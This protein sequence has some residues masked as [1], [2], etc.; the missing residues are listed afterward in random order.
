MPC[1]D[2][3]AERAVLATVL[4]VPAKWDEASA[5]LDESKFYGESSRLV[6]RSLHELRALG[7]PFDSVTVAKWLRKHEFWGRQV[8]PT[9]FAS[10]LADTPSVANVGA[11]A[12]I[13]HE[14]WVVRQLNELTSRAAA[15]TSEDRIDDVESYANGLSRRI[16]ELSQ[17]AMSE[18]MSELGAALQ[19]S[20]SAIQSMMQTGSAGRGAACGVRSID[21]ASGGMKTGRV[22]VLAARSGMG[23]TTLAAQIAMHHALSD[24]PVLY[25]TLEMKRVEIANRV[26]FCHAGVD[27]SKLRANPRSA[28]FFNAQDWTA[29]ATSCGKLK[30]VPMLI[31]EATNL[32]VPQ[33]RAKITQAQA[34]FERKGKKLHTVVIDHALKM[35]GTNPRHDKRLQMIEVTGGVKDFAKNLDVSV[36]E[37]SQLSRASESRTTKDHRPRI[38]DLKESGSFEEDADQVWFLYRP[39]KYEPDKSKHDHSAEF[40]L[41]KVRDDGQEGIV[42]LHFDGPAGRFLDR[43]DEPTP[44]YFDE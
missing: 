13:V 12:K 36:L 39:D 6:W 29:L 22:Y 32:S 16:V 17:P 9:W 25:F 20:F 44:D 15:D 27:R 2:E 28:E 40:I 42:R 43:T 37:L 8:D 31:D 26:L 4:L 10:M 24:L 11:H 35:R 3:A 14:C 5:A 38:S 19:E 34:F 41:A 21:H 33:M 7:V 1:F 30:S 18:T 23:K